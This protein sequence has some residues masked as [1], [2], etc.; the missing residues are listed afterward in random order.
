MDLRLV[1]N[2]LY[3]WFEQYLLVSC[4]YF[5]KPIEIIIP[6]TVSK[7]AMFSQIELEMI[8]QSFE[9]TSHEL[10][11][12]HY[13]DVIMDTIASQIPSLTIVYSIAYSDADQRKHESSAS[14]AVVHGIHR[15]P[16]NTPHKWPVM[17]KIFPFDDVIMVLGFVVYVVTS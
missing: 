6:I 2:H 17:R 5:Q 14:V 9:S 1:F 3:I 11:A 16:M 15:G 10:C 8:L 12:R 4:T 13:G 7:I